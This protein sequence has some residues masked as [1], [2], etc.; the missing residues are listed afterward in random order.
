MADE[1]TNYVLQVYLTEAAARIGDVTTALKVDGNG[2]VHT[3]I[4]AAGYG[5]WTH[6]KYWYRIE[7]N[8][9]VTEFYIDWDDGEDNDPKGKANFTTI[10]LDTPSFVG[11]AGHIYTG[12]SKTISGVS[13]QGV[14]YPKLRVKS[15][16]GYWSKIFMNKYGANT[17]L[18][19]GTDIP[20]GETAVAAG[21]NNTYRV[22]LDGV[23]S[24]HRIPAFAPQIKPPIAILK[25]DKK[26][27]Y[28]G[29]YDRYLG[30]QDGIPGASESVDLIEVPNSGSAVRTG[31]KVRVT[32]VTSGEQNDASWGG[33]GDIKV[34][35]MSTGDTGDNPNTITNVTKIMKVEL[36][37]LLEDNVAYNGSNPSSTK[38]YPGEKMQ[39]IYGSIQYANPQTIA[40]VSLGN[41]IVEKDDPRYTITYDLTESFTRTSEQSISNYYIDDGGRRHEAGYNTE[42]IQIDVG[43][44]AKTAVSD[45]LSNQSNL[46]DVTSGVTRSS[47]AFDHTYDVVDSDFRWLPRQILTRGQIKVSNPLGTVAK[48]NIQ[49]SYLEHWINENH[50]L[51]YSDTM[52]DIAAYNWTSEISSSGILAGKFI[53]S[54]TTWKDLGPDNNRAWNTLIHSQGDSSGMASRQFGTSATTSLD[55]PD[56]TTIILCARDKKWTKQFWDMAW[57][58]DEVPG[59]AD[60]VIPGSSND[61]EGVGTIGVGHMNIRV[62]A[63]YSAYEHSSNVRYAWKPLKYLNKTKHPDYDDSTWYTDGVFEWE[64]QDDWVAVDPDAIDDNYYPSG[65]YYDAADSTTFAYSTHN[66][67]PIQQ[68]QTVAHRRLWIT[69]VVCGMKTIRNMLLC[70]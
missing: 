5:Y 14:Y 17:G 67:H 46:H 23:S 24:I 49:Y 29:I 11:I 41:P 38:L 64:D 36:L 69:L 59:R 54:S 9:P 25:S 15:I 2:Y 18:P 4:Q 52:E 28:A 65:Q 43:T 35:D 22:E 70:F 20:A 58:N 66:N 31:V 55:D 39:L 56:N 62:Q 68:T 12:N 27:I 16:E 7:A 57:A 21:R 19:V 51:N 50:T 63:F 26:R 40:E 37:N 6:E 42:D 34:T 3:Q 33:R 48:R 45:V 47:Y 30:G 13:A 32:Y 61:T 60:M 44:T 1:P 10:K 53:D 8:E